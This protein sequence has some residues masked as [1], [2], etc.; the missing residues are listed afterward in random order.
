ML[1]GTAATFIMASS[2]GAQNGSSPIPSFAH[3][4]DGIAQ[5]R[6]FW[7]QVASLY[8]VDRSMANLENGYWG[9]MAKPVLAEFVR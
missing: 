6:A 4:G 5:D 3:T 2:A 9:I 1:S 7:E 8:D